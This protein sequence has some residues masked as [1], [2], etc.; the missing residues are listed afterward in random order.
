MVPNIGRPLATLDVACGDGFLLSV[1]ASRRQHGLALSGIDMSFGEL[2]CARSRLGST[3][4]LVR[5]RAQDMPFRSQRL[6]YVLCHMA[7]MLMEDV[8]RVL[9]EVH[10]ILKPGGTFAAVVGAAARPSVPLSAFRDA[11]A[12]RSRQPQWSAVRFGDHRIRDREGLIELL[13]RDFCNVVVE[14]IYFTVKGNPQEL[15]FWFQGMYDLHLLSIQDQ[16]LVEHDFYNTIAITCGLDG[17]LEV[18]QGLRY[19]GAQAGSSP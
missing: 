15:W 14:D 3:V 7:L 18:A 11:L 2:A 1:L 17:P 13:S 16:R 8:E 4:P 9:S 5:A 12:R 19:V 6:D 10:R